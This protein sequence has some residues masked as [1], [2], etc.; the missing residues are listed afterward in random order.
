MRRS[1]LRG[2]VAVF[3]SVL[4]LTGTPEML[5]AQQAPDATVIR[6]YAP[7]APGAVRPGVEVSG[8]VTGECFAASLADQSRADAWRCMSANRI[9][10][11]CFQG[12]EGSKIMLACPENPW[13]PR[14]TL[15]VPSKVPP[16]AQANRPG[17]GQG[18]PW[19]LELTNGTRC[20]FLTGATS[21]VAGMRVNYGCV[22]GPSVV[23]EL[24]RT[25]PQWRA[26]VDPGKGVTVQ[27]QGLAV[28]WY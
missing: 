10:D 23:G 1:N 16:R 14:V 6:L 22:G 25:L 4:V 5:R 15:L 26:F 21:A 17:I 27:M 13:S 7:F 11:P 9:L 19:A 3:S 12:F 20:V 24:D 18:L 2:C 8:R 28:V